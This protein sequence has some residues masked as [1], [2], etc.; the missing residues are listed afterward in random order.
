MAY[1]SLRDQRRCPEFCEPHGDGDDLVPCLGPIGHLGP[2][3]PS[4]R[5]TP[6]VRSVRLEGDEEGVS[7]EHDHEG[8][9]VIMK[10]D[11]DSMDHDEADDVL[12]QAVVLQEAL[13]IYVQR[14]RKYRG[15]WQRY[16][17]LDSAMH[18]RS[19]GLRAFQR[20]MG[21]IKDGAIP[22]NADVD[23]FQDFINYAA[24]GIRN[25]RSGRLGDE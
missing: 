16:G 4:D 6:G 21:W 8:V 19:K 11:V 14:N 17:A 5:P 18:L 12:A 15:A 20:V 10:L 23:D 3:V 9:H 24:F 1:K 25:I 2:H 7:V 22:P 13:N